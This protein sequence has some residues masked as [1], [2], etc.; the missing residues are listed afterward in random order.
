[1]LLLGGLRSIW[2]GVLGAIF[3]VWLPEFLRPVKEYETV[4]YSFLLLATIIVLPQGIAGSIV[5][6][7][8]KAV[9]R[10]KSN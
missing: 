10:V 2:G 3:Y 9:Q 5:A 1:M 6:L 7:S 4:I 8:K